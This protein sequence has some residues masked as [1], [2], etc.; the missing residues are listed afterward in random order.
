MKVPVI[1]PVFD[2]N[3]TEGYSACK[4]AVRSKGTGPEKVTLSRK[5]PTRIAKKKF[6]MMNS[7]FYVG[8]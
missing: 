6:N 4:R 7:H 2:R 8:T 1:F 5:W 3:R